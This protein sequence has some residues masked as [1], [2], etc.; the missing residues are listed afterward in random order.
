VEEQLLARCRERLPLYMLPAR[1]VVREG[2]LPRNP[3]GKI[4]R[5]QLAD[6][7]AALYEEEGA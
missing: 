2:P 6:E 3:N 4:D 1:I 5:R 7:V